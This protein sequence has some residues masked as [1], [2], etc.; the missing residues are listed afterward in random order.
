M[1][2]KDNGLVLLLFKT[3]S[4]PAISPLLSPLPHLLGDD[5]AWGGARTPRSAARDGSPAWPR[6]HG[7]AHR[8]TTSDTPDSPDT[9]ET[10]LTRRAKPDTPSLPDAQV[11]FGLLTHIKSNTSRRWTDNVW[12][13]SHLNINIKLSWFFCSVDVIYIAVVSGNVCL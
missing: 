7:A 1:I 10:R 3:N 8:N 4:G 5:K 11:H 13:I 2:W 9:P 12:T 6:S